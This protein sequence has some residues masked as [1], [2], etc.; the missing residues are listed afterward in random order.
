MSRNIKSF[1]LKVFVL[2][3]IIIVGFSIWNNISNAPDKE[4]ELNSAK[5]IINT[6]NKSN[7]KWVNNSWLWKTWVA[8]T[9]NIWTKYKQR[10]E[11][12][13]TIYKDVFS[14]NNMVQNWEVWS[15]ELIS[16]NMII[17][18]EYK[19]TLKTDIKWLLA[20][21]KNKA[22][23]L[24]A[25]IEQFE[26]RY[27]KSVKQSISLNEQKAIFEREMAEA[28]SQIEILKVKINTDYKNRDAI[29]SKENI[30]N[31]LNEK[32]KYNYARTYIIYINQFLRDYSILN[33]YN[34]KLLDT[35]INNKEAILKESYVVIPN[36]WV[37]LLKEFDLLYEEAE[38]KAK[39]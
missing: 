26:F 16:A 24:D 14:V 34:K 5:E 17:I 19:N 39:K 28:N 15:D 31:Y 22:E 7:F 8:I 35:I 33:D 25:L 9:T 38:Y 37:E 21:S 18:E 29:A 10:T 30:T 27:E 3:T 1:L 32:N 20:Q 11:I 12:P 2:T 23:I 36:T 6:T 13:A 4:K